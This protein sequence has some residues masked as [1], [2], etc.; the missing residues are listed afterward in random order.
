MVSEGDKPVAGGGLQALEI[1]EDFPEGEV[2]SDV[3]LEVCHTSKVAV[4]KPCLEVEVHTL[5]TTHINTGHVDGNE[6]HAFSNAG[7]QVSDRYGG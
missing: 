4:D 7:E 2:C 1:C 5:Y 3:E 6:L